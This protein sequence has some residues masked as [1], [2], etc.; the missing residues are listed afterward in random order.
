[1]KCLADAAIIFGC[2]ATDFYV[3]GIAVNLVLAA[4]V[5]FSVVV[6]GRN[7]DERSA[8]NM[9]TASVGCGSNGGHQSFAGEL[10]RCDER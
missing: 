4:A 2:P 10:G 1:M 8:T 6:G 5:S 3:H 9:G 7:R